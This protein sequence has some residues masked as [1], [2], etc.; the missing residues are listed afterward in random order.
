[1]DKITQLLKK[2]LL[3]L[4]HCYMKTWS[5]SHPGRP[6]LQQHS[7][8][9][10]VRPRACN[11]NQQG[12]TVKYEII[13]KTT[14]IKCNIRAYLTVNI[15]GQNSVN[16]DITVRFKEKHPEIQK[17]HHLQKKKKN[18][19]NKPF[20]WGSVTLANMLWQAAFFRNAVTT[21]A[22]TSLLR[23]TVKGNWQ[24][25]GTVMFVMIYVTVLWPKY[26]QK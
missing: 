10:C 24:K 2:N 20:F 13:K 22:S 9:N 14:E 5:N 23:A 25:K 11:F 8:R 17:H 6:W 18:L 15:Q 1:M 26:N 19:N 12:Q 4:F 7:L 21:S 3:Y 16:A